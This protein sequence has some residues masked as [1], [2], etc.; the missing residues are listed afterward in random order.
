MGQHDGFR[1]LQVWQRSKDL[2]V[3]IYTMTREG[4]IA[5]DFG[6]IDQIR[7][8]AV[9]IP[10]NIAEGDE[11]ETNKEAVRFLYIAKGSLAELRTQLEIA[12]HVGYIKQEIWQTLDNE[13]GQIGRMLGSLIKSRSNRTHN[14]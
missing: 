4:T 10:S 1:G 3:T 13:C 9:S 6:L 8:A 12:H 5:R 7:R 2:A 11:R 14:R